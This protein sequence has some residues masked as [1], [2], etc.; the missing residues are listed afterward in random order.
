MVECRLQQPSVDL[1]QRAT[2]RNGRLSCLLDL[3]C[4]LLGLDRLVTCRQTQKDSCQGRVDYQGHKEGRRQGDDD[5]FGKIGH[6]LPHHPRPE[7]KGTESGNRGQ[8]GGG[9]RLGHLGGAPDCCFNARNAL[10]HISKNVLHDHD[11]IV[12]KH[13]Q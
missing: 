13:A 10:L 7:K 11:G 6:E 4:A 2:D 8:G 9:N 5:G 1:E 3:L 12:H